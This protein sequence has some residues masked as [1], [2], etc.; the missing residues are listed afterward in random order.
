ML[1]RVKRSRSRSNHLGVPPDVFPLQAAPPARRP[2]D[3]VGARAVRRAVGAWRSPAG[4]PP[5]ARP[6]LIVVAA[7]AAITYAWGADKSA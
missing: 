3:L 5:W 4:Q 2:G 6:A 7:V 1:S